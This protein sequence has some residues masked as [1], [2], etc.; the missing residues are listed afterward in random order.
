[1]PELNQTSGSEKYQR[2]IYGKEQQM[3]AEKLNKIKEEKEANE[4]AE[5]YL[6]ELEDQKEEE[7]NKLTKQI[8]DITTNLLNDP[9]YREFERRLNQFG[10]SL[11]FVNEIGFKLSDKLDELSSK[12]RGLGLKNEASNLDLL[13]EQYIVKRITEVGK[14]KFL[15]KKKTA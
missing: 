7:K 6:R 2:K 11:D 1:M 5:Q 12:A 15:E 9:D 8:N 3:I 10:A 14:G 13:K 4:T